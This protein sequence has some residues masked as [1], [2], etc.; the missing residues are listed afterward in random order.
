M[1]SPIFIFASGQRCGSTLLQRLLNSHKDIMIWGEHLGV[2]NNFY[3]LHGELV[4]WGEEFKDN[5]EVF[6]EQG[7]NS[8]VPNLT[9]ARSEIVN[10]SRNYVCSLFERPALD[11]GKS[12]WGLKEVR[13]DIHI[14]RFLQGLFPNAKFIWMTRN[15]ID[16]YSS[17]KDWEESN[18]EWIREWTEI[19]VKDWQRINQSFLSGQN[20]LENHILIKLED[21]VSD[22]DATVKKICHLLDIEDQ[23]LNL[24]VLNQKKR[25]LYDLG[26]AKPKAFSVEDFT[27]A[28]W[29]LISTPEI[30]ETCNMLG[31]RHPKS[32][33]TR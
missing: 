30:I 22:K 33:M 16:C 13:Y 8:F 12:W 17:I 32:N 10:A 4:N 9:P 14:A 3:Q 21:L 28:D 6:L 5:R 27:E 19:F 20:E 24:G 7:Y 1:N 15:I 23:E 18:V 31:Y 25:N 2:L 29:Q 26:A 11:L